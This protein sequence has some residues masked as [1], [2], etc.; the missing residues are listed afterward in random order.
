[1][2]DLI[3]R[4]EAGRLNAEIDPLTGEQVQDIVTQV[5]ATP[6]LTV[7]GYWMSLNENGV[8]SMT[9]RIRSA[10]TRA[11]AWSAS[12]RTTANSSPP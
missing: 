12:G 3:F 9:S 8:F 6:R 1:M 7:T 2:T 4:A 11:V 5:L 10:T